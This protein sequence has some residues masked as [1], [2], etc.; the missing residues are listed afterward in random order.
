MTVTLNNTF[1][2]YL[3]PRSSRGL[4]RQ[5]RTENSTPRNVRNV[6]HLPFG[7]DMEYAHEMSCCLLQGSAVLYHR[8]CNSQFTILDLR[9][10][11]VFCRTYSHL[12]WAVAT[13][14][15][16]DRLSNFLQI[17][18][19]FYLFLSLAVVAFVLSCNFYD[20]PFPLLMLC[21]LLCRL[22]ES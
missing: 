7:K 19:T 1:V 18:T 17:L 11:L 5:T 21:F 13:I 4:T 20:I 14:I 2:I 8:S 16:W 3:I 6:F 22:M 12:S 10:C 15:S 9:M